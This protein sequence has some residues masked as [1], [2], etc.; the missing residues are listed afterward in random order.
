MGRKQQVER[1]A[2]QA[3]HIYIENELQNGPLTIIWDSNGEIVEPHPPFLHR[4][5]NDS[6]YFQDIFSPDI[7]RILQSWLTNSCDKL[8]VSNR[9]CFPFT[10]MVCDLALQ[11]T[12]V[13]GFNYT[14]ATVIHSKQEEQYRLENMHTQLMAGQLAAG[15]VHE[16]RNPLTSIKGFIQLLQAGIKQEEQYYKVMIAEIEKIEN[17]T[18]QLLHVAKPL[19]EIVMQEECVESMIQDVLLLFETNTSMRNVCFSTQMEDTIT[20]KCNRTQIKQA[21]MNIIKNAIEAMEYN[22]N[23]SILAYKNGS[24]CE[25]TFQ[26]NGPGIPEE[27]LENIG[28]P[29]VSTKQT[30]TGL[31]LLITKKLVEENNGAIS[32]EANEPDGCIVKISFPIS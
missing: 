15:Y 6:I 17:I 10:Q 13:N 22:G 16:I 3:L 18:T 12:H 29:F 7:N 26:D 32:V 14:I 31:G 11:K 30:G 23:I 8:K 21:I 28:K 27:I 9:N 19:D 24:Y 1:A 5:S 2:L 4:L 20:V 25:L